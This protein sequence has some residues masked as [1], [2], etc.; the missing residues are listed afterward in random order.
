MKIKLIAWLV[1]VDN[2]FL[3]VISTKINNTIFYP[4]MK[5]FPTI[6]RTYELFRVIYSF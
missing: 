2:I 3:V 6:E 4:H 5:T 1:I